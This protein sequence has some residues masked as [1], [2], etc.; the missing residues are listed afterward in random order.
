ME[1]L[2][3]CQEKP[4]HML[5]EKQ[6]DRVDPNQLAS[7]EPADLYLHCL[8]KMVKNIEKLCSL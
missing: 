5:D 6:L 2:S 8:K 7:S 4:Y 3:F 1:I